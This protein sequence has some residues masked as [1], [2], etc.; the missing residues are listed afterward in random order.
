MRFTENIV[1]LKVLD[2][3]NNPVGRLSDLIISMH[4][5]YPVVVAVVVKFDRIS[6]IGETPLIEKARNIKLIVPFDQIH[7]SPNA[8]KLRMKEEE[9]HSRYMAKDEILIGRDII[10]SV[11]TTSDGQSIGRVN[12]VVIFEKDN[13]LEIFGLG[14]GIIG[15]VAKL[16]LEI[17]IELLDKGF[18]KSFVETVINWK[19]VKDYHPHKNEIMLSVT[20][21]IGASDQIDYIQS[22]EFEKPS[23]FKKPPFII[24]PWL[25]LEKAFKKKK[26]K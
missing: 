18:G 13:R 4:G 20:Q 21:K 8:I 19:Y 26:K 24:I 15:I 5:K 25:F 7:F 22:K 11:I 1:G 17:P 6:F 10:D 16:G 9:L 12:D 23:K 2:L 14:V 3:K